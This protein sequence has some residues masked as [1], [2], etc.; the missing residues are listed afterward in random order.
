[1]PLYLVRHGQADVGIF[2]PDPSLTVE[3]RAEVD[4]M[5][6]LSSAF[7]LPVSQI[8]YSSKIRTRQTAAIMG[9]YLKPSSGI[10]ETKGIDP[11]DDVTK[12]SNIIETSNNTMLVSHL[13]FLEGL[14][15]YLILGTTD[16]TI[17]MFQTA[18]IVCLDKKS[19]EE[20]WHIRWALM[21]DMK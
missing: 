7:A 13:P 3:G 4:R 2:N 8:L 12:I 16:K 14:L 11:N 15:S 17:I 18:G 9:H 1:M 10:K 20:F 5:A 6:H 19:E 21:P